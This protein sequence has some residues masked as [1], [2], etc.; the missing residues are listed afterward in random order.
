M[1]ASFTRDSVGKTY[2][3]KRKQGRNLQHIDV[4]SIK[5]MEFKKQTL[6][7]RYIMGINIFIA[8]N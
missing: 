8:L 2:I 3:L 7:E 4:T 6:D 1:K 5:Q